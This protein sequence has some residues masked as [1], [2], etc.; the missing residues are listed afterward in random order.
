MKDE[1]SIVITFSEED[2]KYIGMKFD[3][4]DKEDLYQAVWEMISTYMEM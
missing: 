3:I 2:L 4:E 1:M